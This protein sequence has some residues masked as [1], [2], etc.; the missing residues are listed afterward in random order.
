MKSKNN[1]EIKPGQTLVLE[2]VEQK[3]NN[4]KKRKY[5]RWKVKEVYEHTVLCERKVKL[6]TI[7]ESFTMFDIAEKLITIE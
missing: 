6:G 4:E 5:Q 1:L 7:R 3:P 2:L